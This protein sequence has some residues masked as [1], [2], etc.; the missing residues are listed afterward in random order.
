MGCEETKNSIAFI[1]KPG[2]FIHIKEKFEGEC[3]WRDQ[4]SGEGDTFRVFLRYNY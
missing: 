4:Q 3:I 2:T 1:Y